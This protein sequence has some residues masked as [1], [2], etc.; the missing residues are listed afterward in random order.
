MY[1]ALEDGPPGFPQD[2]TCPVVLGIPLRPFW[3]SVTGLSPAV[4]G[5]SRP[6]TYPSRSYNAVPQHPSTRTSLRSYSLRTSPE[7]M[8]CEANYESK[9]LG[10]S[11]FARHYFRNHN[12][13]LFLQV[14]RCFSSLGSLPHPMYSDGDIPT[15][16][17]IGFPIR[18]SPDQSLLGGSPEL[19]AACHVL[20]RQLLP[21]HPPYALNN[22]TKI[23]LGSLKR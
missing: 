18:K 21:R 3:I 22:L 17:G 4:A 12:C 23:R 16:A 20:L 13:F 2:F 6:F 9:G 5:L 14:L 15:F 10:Y 1:L 11:D 7:R 19:I 8:V